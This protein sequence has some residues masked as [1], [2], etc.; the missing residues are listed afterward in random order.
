MN[1][2]S[3]VGALGAQVRSIDITGVMPLPPD[4]NRMRRG[5]CVREDEVATDGVQPDDHAGPGVLVEV[6]GHQP[7]V[8]TANGQLD[9]RGA[10]GAGRR[11]G[12]GAA[13]AVDLDGEVDVLAGA[14]AGERPVGLQGQCDAARGLPAHRDD[15][16]AGVSRGPGR[17]DQLG[18]PVH[19]MGPGQQVDQR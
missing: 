14:K 15:L 6:V 9:V 3:P 19:A 16:R 7:A 2:I 10:L 12:P 18:V 4:T 17:V 13:T 1:A 11:V 8:V 5:R